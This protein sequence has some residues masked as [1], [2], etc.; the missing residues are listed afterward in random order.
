MKCG[1]LPFFLENNFHVF[2]LVAGCAPK[3]NFGELFNSV[4]SDWQPIS[5]SMVSKVE[6]KYFEFGHICI[7]RKS[8]R[9]SPLNNKSNL[10]LTV[11]ENYHLALNQIA[12]NFNVAAYTVHNILKKKQNSVFKIRWALSIRCM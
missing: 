7:L 3:K 4:H 5:W 12:S 10:L 8:W 1:G 2:K 9:H 6:T 11:E